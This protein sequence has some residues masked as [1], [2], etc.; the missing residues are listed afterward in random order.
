MTMTDALQ[1]SSGPNLIGNPSFTDVSD[2]WATSWQ[3]SDPVNVTVDSGSHGNVS[4]AAS[5]LKIVGGPEPRQTTSALIE[6]EPTA[7]YVLRA[8]QNVQDL[9]A[10][11]WAVWIDEFSADGAWLSGQWAW[12]NYDNHVGYRY[13]QYRPTS[14]SVAGVRVTF[15]TEQDSALTLYLDAV[16][17]KREI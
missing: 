17:L 10:G 12:G 7:S 4:G 1:Y 9:T 2:G 8:Y 5:S 13:Y 6:T 11:G 14:Q 3:R 16:E 15:Y